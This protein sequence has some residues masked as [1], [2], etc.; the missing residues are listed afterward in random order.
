MSTSMGENSILPSAKSSN[1]GNMD[2]VPCRGEQTSVRP[3]RA[4]VTLS[5][6]AQLITR[7]E[8]KPKHLQSSSFIC[9]DCSKTFSDLSGLVRHQERKHALQKLNSCQHCGQKFALLSSLQLHKCHSASSMCQECRDKPQWDSSCPTCGT[10]PS[11]SHHDDEKSPHACIPCGQAFSH[12]QE[13]LHHQQAGGCQQATAPTPPSP[14]CTSMSLSTCT[15][16]S[17]TFRSLAEP[18]SHLCNFHSPK[19][20]K[21]KK[22][23][24]KKD[25]TTEMSFPC[26]SCDKIFPQTSLLY[27]H[28]KEEH[29]RDSMVRKQ[30]TVKTTRKRRRS[31]PYPCLHCGKL[32]LHHMTHQ[33]H[34]RHCSTNHQAHLALSAESTED[35]RAGKDGNPKAAKGLKPAKKIK[36]LKEGEHQGRPKTKSQP[37]LKDSKEEETDKEDDEDGKYPCASCE[38]VFRTVAALKVHENVHP[39]ADTC[40]RCSVCTGGMPL[41]QIPE[42]CQ[43]SIFHCVPCAEA[44]MALDTFLEHCQKHLLHDKDDDEDELSDD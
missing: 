26:R 27:Q 33:A 10:E 1:G 41:S 17:R 11:G 2:S 23:K 43:K 4:L 6:L 8:Y 37:A 42:D 32:F 31:K 40:K 35:S 20:L 16:C 22:K 29:W 34:F 24:K 36:S 21:K 19:K 3:R 15:L 7:V 38:E 14:S 28:R 12:K 18:Y 25:L 44:F 13:L 9:K 5:K 39:P 30:Q